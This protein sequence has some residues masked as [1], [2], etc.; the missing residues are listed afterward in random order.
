[1]SVAAEQFTFLQ[2][3]VFKKSAI[4]LADSKAYLVD[5]R[6]MPI[7]RTMGLSDANDVV[8]KLRLTR[9]AKLEELVI[10]A[11]TTNETLWFRDQR[12]FDALRKTVLPELIARKQATR[13]LS[14]WSAASSSGQELYS[15]AISLQEDFPQLQNGWRVDLL[16]TDL[17]S[18][19]VRKATDARYSA[20]EINR[21]LP[22]SILVRY[23]S[24]EGA[25]YRLNESVRKNVRFQRMNLAGTWP[26][27]PMFDV[28]LLRNV[29]IYFD[30]ATKRQILSQ[31]RRRLAPG[32]VLFLG[33]AETTN[34]L[35]E[36]FESVTAN[37]AVFYKV[38]E[39][40]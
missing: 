32:G 3:L 35:A 27:L 11:M 15:V 9:D 38:K 26:V 4:V 22:A 23:F 2:D 19:M 24:Q 36:E 33:T 31:A 18:E 30:V 34:G 40:N 14:I 7:A 29:L 21:G 20:M 28:I 8:S 39:G 16:G 1:M 17:N 25:T 6:L 10:E 13:Q 5:S 12:P 37:G